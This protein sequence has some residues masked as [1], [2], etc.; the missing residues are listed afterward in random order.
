[1]SEAL[2]NEIKKNF[3]RF[4]KDDYFENLLCVLSKDWIDGLVSLRKSQILVNKFGVKKKD[5]QINNVINKLSA[6]VPKKYKNRYLKYFKSIAPI[7]NLLRELSQRILESDLWKL[8][9]EMCL[10]SF[11]ARFETEY[12]KIHFGI[13]RHI[14]AQ[15]NKS[16]NMGK[17]VF[18]NTINGSSVPADIKLQQLATSLDRNLRFIGYHSGQIPLVNL[19]ISPD[20][21]MASKLQLTGELWN[22]LLYLGDKVSLFD[23]YATKSGKDPEVYYYQPQN[24]QK[25]ILHEIGNLRE[26]EWLLQQLFDTEGWSA[27]KLKTP[28]PDDPLFPIN[29]NE[30]RACVELIAMCNSNRILEIEFKNKLKVKE[31]I[32]AWHVISEIA[33]PNFD[34]KKEPSLQSGTVFDISNF[35]II[36]RE[37]LLASLIGKGK[38]NQSAATKSLDI[39]N[40]WNMDRE[41]FSSPLFPT[42]DDRYLVLTSVFAS[43]NPVR[44]VFRL[45]SH[46]EIDI[47]FKGETTEKKLECLFE[48]MEFICKPN[49]KFTDSFGQGEI[50]LIAFKENIFFI[51]ESKNIVPN[52]SVSDRY[53]TWKFFEKKASNQAIR[54][55]KYVNSNLP[56]ICKTLKIPT[57]SRDLIQIIPVIFTNLFGFTGAVI[58][59]V[60]V[61]DLSAL[62]KFAT[63][64]YVHETTIV[65]KIK[66]KKLVKV[67][68]EGDVPTAAELLNH[69]IFPFQIEHQAKRL[70]TTTIT[71]KMNKKYTLG[72]FDVRE[73]EDASQIF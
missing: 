44:S 24:K 40:Y 7:N 4:G 66:T 19:D 34:E 27:L 65:N 48:K 71:Q 63:D 42:N 52:E 14:Y 30:V 54:G 26:S 55:A 58:N 17:S 38:L 62:G 25:E 2:I 49:H 22:S 15:K 31:Y 51:C 11:L 68:Y 73:I 3:S 18:L 28:N 72:I 35:L 21:D 45:L 37:D 9:N 53:R 33:M 60:H 6:A 61:S 59:G 57:I 46:D 43:G 5:D 1:M 29:D 47:S 39:L 8:Q 23:W 70:M 67:L 69:L 36:S 20:L 12:A 32:R 56:T 10:T 41:V 50:D 64:K 16:I 13:Q